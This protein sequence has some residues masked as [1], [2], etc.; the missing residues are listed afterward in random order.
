MDLL[1]IVPELHQ[2]SIGI[3]ALAFAAGVA[4]SI[5]FC[6]VPA[7][8]FLIGYVGDYAKRDKRQGFF[9]SLCFM[10]G[11]A[12][13]LAAAGALAGWFGSHFTESS[14]VYYVTGGILVLLGGYL[15][16][17]VR[18]PVASLLPSWLVTGGAGAFLMGIPFA[19]VASPYT[20]SVIFAALAWLAL[21]GK[22]L[23]GFIVMFAFGLGRSLLILLAGGFS[24]LLRR[25]KRLN[26]WGGPLKR[27]SG[28]GLLLLAAWIF[29]IA[30]TFNNG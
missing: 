23:E 17:M 4:S 13:T 21:Q 25:W 29:W 9:L 15:A 27:Y 8:L 5:S 30:V 22:P 20:A 1:E 11:L 3:L 26:T 14:V 12:S 10:L 19:F 7:A 24:D 28:Y 6:T 16:G 18:F 2:L